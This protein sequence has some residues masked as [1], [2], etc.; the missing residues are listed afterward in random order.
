MSSRMDGLDLFAVQGTLKHLLQ[1]HSS[2][3]SV[4]QGSAFFIVLIVTF[5]HAYWKTIALARQTFAGKVMSLLLNCG[6]GE[7]A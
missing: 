5:I 1:Q 4:L 6:V 3:A 2:K 7:D